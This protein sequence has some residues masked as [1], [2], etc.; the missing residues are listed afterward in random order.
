LRIVTWN[1]FQSPSSGAPEEISEMELVFQAIGD[2]TRP[3]FSRT[4]DIL[5][6]QEQ[7]TNFSTTDRILN[8]LNGTNGPGGYARG[9]LTP[10]GG[11]NN[12]MQTVVYRTNSVQ[13]MAETQA[14]T[15]N[16]NEGGSR[17]TMRYQFRP[18]GYDS[19]ADFYVFNSHLRPG[20]STNDAGR[21][22]VEVSELRTNADTLGQGARLI[23]VGDMN[24]YCTNDAG[25]IAFT[26]AGAGQAFD[27]VNAVGNW[28]DNPD[29]LAVQTQNPRSPMD[30]RFDFQL[31]TAEVLDGRGFS[32]ITNSYWAFGNTGSHNFD[33]AI[34]SGNAVSGLNAMLTNYSTAQISNVFNALISLSDHLPVVADYRLP[35]S[36]GVTVDSL[37]TRAIIGA[38]LTNAFAVSNNAPVS[39]TDGADFLAYS[40]AGS[41]QVTASG[42]G[43]N[44]ALTTADTRSFTFS[45]A[46]VGTNTGALAVNAASPQAAHA[47]ITN[48]FSMDVLDHATASFASNSIT[49]LLDLDLGNISFGGA[50]AVQTFDLFNLPGAAGGAWTAR[51]DLDSISE[52]DLSGLFSTTLAPFSNLAAGAS[53]GYA[54]SMAAAALGSFTGS[55]TLNL[56]DENLPG[57]TA[58]SLS[59][60]VRGTVNGDIDVGAGQTRTESNAITGAGA[61]IKEGA[62][63]LVLSAMNT[64]SGSTTVAAGVLAL[65]ATGSLA[66]TTAILIANGAKFDVSARTNGFT[67]A[68]GQTLGGSGTVE[69]DLAISGTVRPGES[70]GALVL[71]NG[72][73]SWNAGGSY[74]WE[75]YDTDDGP[76]IGWDHIDV[77]GGTL[78]FNGLGAETPFNIN[79]LSLSTLPSTAGPL[80]GFAPGSNYTWTILTASNAIS[81]FNASYFNLNTTG[82]APYNPYSG[83]FS[84]VA[85]G[86][87][88]NLLYT[89]SATPIPE[90]GTWLAAALLT[91]A[92][93]LRWCRRNSRDQS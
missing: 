69:G 80:S 52:T 57:A 90:P 65:D 35:A 30:D 34:N 19:T 33:Q 81:G 28:T 9:T 8:L 13:L 50:N 39:V 49:S 88:L 84:L 31:V 62:G 26:N 85:N 16:T 55:F 4:L 54:V 18:L 48:H 21:R 40:F 77:A 58:Q 23:Y 92:A 60:A 2:Q 15:I 1:T 75:I 73:L 72:D 64:F 7:A 32:Y 37:A 22:G 12:I 51:L 45:A 93:Y 61:L 67:I 66:N 78:L 43:T 27:P 89:G 86:K 70:P 14:T 47:N 42:G 87:N 24:F 41:G 82:F 68:T 91:G 63:T 44:W 83:S 5:L 46:T 20:D 11:V 59:I 76:G 74:D 79:I 53:S 25:W 17:A 71:T 36:M 10:V 38:V 3:G 29:F 6:L 56:S